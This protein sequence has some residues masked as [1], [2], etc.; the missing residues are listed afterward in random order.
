MAAVNYAKEYQS[1]LSNAWPHVLRFGALYAAPNNGRFRFLRSNIIEVPTLTTTG[2]K[3]ASRDAI[4][5]PG[6][7]WDNGWVP[8]ELT[9]HRYWDTLVH[10]RDIEQTNM[11]ASI[12]NITKTYNE[13]Q[14]FPEMDAYTISKI[15][16]DFVELGKTVD[17]TAITTDN[18]LTVFDG[19]YQQL[20]EDLVPMTGLI[21]YVTPAVNTTLKNAKA[22]SRQLAIG[23]QKAVVERALASL[24]EVKIEVVPSVLM[25][26]LYDFS[27]G[28]TPAGA[29]KQ[30]NMALIQPQ[31]IITPVTYSAAALDEPCA[32]TNMQYYYYEE[33]DEDV[34]ILPNKETGIAFN[35]QA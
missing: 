29:A 5:E 33:S 12:A 10:P 32:K 11:A 15:Y 8:L 22:L 35:A 26:T 1:A 30:I 9:N 18:V 6:R 3:E 4:V 23:P 31:S 28:W 24:D 27:D 19:M 25:K 20:I 14:K 16:A 13:Q 21:L 17:T 34:F 7:H 2:R